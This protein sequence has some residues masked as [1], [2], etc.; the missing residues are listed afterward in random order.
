MMWPSDYK[1]SASLFGFRKLFAGFGRLAVF[2]QQWWSPQGGEGG[3]MG[4]L[5]E[6]Y[7]PAGHVPKL[8][9]KTGL[10]VAF[11]AKPQPKTEVVAGVRIVD[12]RRIYNIPVGE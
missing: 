5:I 7:L 3:S 9:G 11:P 2:L 12:S 8:K 6:W 4:Q 10:L 1:D